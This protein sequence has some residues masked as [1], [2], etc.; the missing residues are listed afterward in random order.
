M[1]KLFKI[2]LI[3]VFVVT[4]G[5]ALKKENIKIKMNLKINNVLTIL[6]K[7]DL[8]I[9]E[10]SNHIIEVIDGIFDYKIMAKISLGKKTWKKITTEE[11]NDFIKLFEAKLK[12]SYMDKLK[13]YTNQK[14]K[15]IDLKPYKKSRLQLETEL[16][17]NDD[18]YRINYNFY[19]NKRNKE[20]FIY[21]VDLLG[22]SIIQTY[23][24]QFQGLLKERTFQ[25]MLILLKERNS[26][27]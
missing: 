20:W 25:E 17:G 9:K 26:K 12:S 1:K 19:K 16:I 14:I 10:K 6:H 13:L 18:I 24:K 5:F 23:R 21:D 7:K 3:L 2:L 4:S 8:S 27:N 22:V 11:R 15:I